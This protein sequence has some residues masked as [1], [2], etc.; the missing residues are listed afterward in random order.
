MKSIL[1]VHLAVSLT[2]PVMPMNHSP[3][4]EEEGEKREE[5]GIHLSINHH[6]IGSISN[7]MDTQIRPV[8]ELLEWGIGTGQKCKPLLPPDSRGP[9]L[10]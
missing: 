5:C 2:T 8:R 3:F 1:L 10:S 4:Q 7:I 9:A 6:G